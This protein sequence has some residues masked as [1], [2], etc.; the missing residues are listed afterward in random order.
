M[1]EQGIDMQKWTTAAS[2]STLMDG[3]RYDFS[4]VRTQPR[5]EELAKPVSFREADER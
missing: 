1:V 3:T 4:Q 5:I 2:K